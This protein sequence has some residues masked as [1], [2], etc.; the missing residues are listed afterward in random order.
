MTLYIFAPFAG[1]IAASMFMRF[2]HNPNLGFL[3]NKSLTTLSE[4]S[5]VNGD[6]VEEKAVEEGVGESENL[7]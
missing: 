4:R 5:S 7:K 3:D 2:V 1:G 6:S